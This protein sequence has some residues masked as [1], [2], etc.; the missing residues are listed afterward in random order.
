MEVVNKNMR[1]KNRLALFLYFT[2]GLLVWTS[3]MWVVVFWYILRDG[4][5]T[6]IEPNMPI[7]ITEFALAICL[8]LC[9]IVA[10]FYAV[11]KRKED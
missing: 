11:I 5:C 4:S 10:M 7:L 6:L 3:V 8:T 1:S 9:G 2:G